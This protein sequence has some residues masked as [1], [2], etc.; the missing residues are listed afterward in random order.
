VKKQSG[1]CRCGHKKE[2]HCWNTGHCTGPECTCVRFEDRSIKLTGMVR[3][4]PMEKSRPVGK[5]E[6]EQRGRICRL[7]RDKAELLTA[8][9]LAASMLDKCG[10]CA[11]TCNAADAGII[12]DA[13]AKAEGRKT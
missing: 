5:I 6:Y 9:K 7:E 10:G 11:S 8:L 3:L 13:I 2:A 12:S 1:V 4:D